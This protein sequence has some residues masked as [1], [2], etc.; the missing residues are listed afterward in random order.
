MGFFVVAFGWF[1]FTTPAL[2][3]NAPKALSVSLLH[4]WS[5]S[6]RIAFGRLLAHASLERLLPSGSHRPA[7]PHT[8]RH[9]EQISGEV[10][11]GL[12]PFTP[13]PL[14]ARCVDPARGA[15]N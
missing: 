5:W 4:A 8:P 6:R 1:V 12:L 10:A 7:V 11:C 15:R 13:L 9:Q 3:N 2:P 14:P